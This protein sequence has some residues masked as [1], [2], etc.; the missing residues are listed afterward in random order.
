MLQNYLNPAKRSVD[1]VMSAADQSLP[2]SVDD[3]RL[4][5]HDGG[6]DLIPKGQWELIQ[7]CVHVT[8]LLAIPRSVREIF[9]FVFS[10][11]SPVTFDDIVASLGIS[12][13]SAS[14]GLRYLRRIGA[15]SVTY[16]ARD[17]RDYYVA[18]TSLGRLFSGYLIENLTH[19]LAD[20]RER[21]AA[22][23][24]VLESGSDLK[25]AHLSTRVDVLLEWN[26]Q[27]SAAISAA[28]ETLTPPYMTGQ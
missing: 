11:P 15:L 6:P 12:S 13:G 14:H 21:I 8:R 23:R 24:H 4:P 27:V 1:P 5:L 28:S 9:G 26:R 3:Q 25:T 17:R 16:V 18:E 7:L 19:H 22:M 10:S 2:A 20:S